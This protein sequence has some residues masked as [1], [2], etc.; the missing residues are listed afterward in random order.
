MKRGVLI[1]ILVTL[2]VFVFLAMMGAFFYLSVTSEPHVPDNAYLEIHLSGPISDTQTSTFSKED[3]IRSFFY[4]INRAKIDNRIKGILLK[5]TRAGGGFA[6]IEE[7]GQLLNE[8]KKSG[9][10]VIAYMEGGS[11]REYYLATFADKIYVLKGSDLFLNGLAS[12]AMFFKNTLAKLGIQAEM[13]HIGEYKTAANTFT[14]DKMTPAHR[15]A[16]K[17]LLDDIYDYTLQQIA[18]NRKLKLEDVKNIIDEFPFDNAAYLKAGLIDKE[19][20]E[21]EIFDVYG[22]DFDTVSYNIYKQSRSPRPFTGN[23]K[24]GIVYASGEIHMGKSGGKSLFGS[25]VMG[26]DT[27]RRQLKALRKNPSV[28]AVV[29]R[30]DSPGG[31]AVASEVIRREAE[32]LA[33]EK[34]LVISMSDLAA[35]GGYWISMCAD[36][37]VIAQPQTITGSIGVVFGKF[38][39]KGLYDKIGI[40]KELVKTSEYADIFSDYRVF[41]EAESAKLNASM[42]KVYKEFLEKVSRSRDLSVEEVDKVGRGRI[43]AGTSALELKL[44]DKLGGLND[45]VNEARKL[46]N[47]PASEKIGLAVYPR[48]KTFMDVISEFMSDGGVTVETNPIEILEAKV[49]MYQKFYPALMMP[50]ELT[51]Q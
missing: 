42:Q 38:V 27:V 4:H 28:K 8:F 2:V 49:K 1:A 31:S 18:K 19:I 50:Y 15:E 6:K 30:I 43:W 17:K 44:V 34:P 48:K 33:K 35:S 12:E 14:E 41:N 32:L 51:I 21:D 23:K 36:H 11:I 29:L 20:Y 25:E 26:S 5:I 40:D 45:A 13:F 47:I 46:A 10:P 22:E 16:I 37:H 24:I 7:I 3:S 9:K 39:M